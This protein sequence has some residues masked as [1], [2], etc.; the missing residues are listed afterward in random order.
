M[1]K[2]CNNIHYMQV[3]CQS[4]N[5]KLVLEVH[6]CHNMLDNNNNQH[7]YSVAYNMNKYMSY[8]QHP[9]PNDNNYNVRQKPS[10]DNNNKLVHM[11]NMLHMILRHYDN[12][13]HLTP[14]D[15][16]NNKLFCYNSP[17]NNKYNH[18]YNDME[19]IHMYKLFQSPAR[20]RI[21]TYMPQNMHIYIRMKQN[22]HMYIHM[23]QSKYIYNYSLQYMRICIHKNIQSKIHMLLYILEVQQQLQYQLHLQQL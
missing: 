18:S 14:F 21:Y 16:Y 4:E 11:Q 9:L 22:M 8:S 23:K 10:C 7:T 1:H 15:P 19:L 13:Y 2:K 3:M 20:M 5:K 6:N 17:N 12:K